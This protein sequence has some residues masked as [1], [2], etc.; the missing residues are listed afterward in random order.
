MKSK[1]KICDRIGCNS[2]ATQRPVLFIPA[3]GYPAKEG[4]CIQL[5]FSLAMCFDC[6]KKMDVAE[7]TAKG[8]QMREICDRSTTGKV[9][10]DYSRAF[11]RSFG[12]NT[13]EGKWITDK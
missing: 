12:L 8:H 5:Q 1:N 10:P 4:M 13:E 7:F 11:I 6:V 9:P 3:K 2:I